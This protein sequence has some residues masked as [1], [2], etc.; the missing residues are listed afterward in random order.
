MDSVLVRLS[1]EQALVAWAECI[2]DLAQTFIV[3]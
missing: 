3:I 1:S 2:L